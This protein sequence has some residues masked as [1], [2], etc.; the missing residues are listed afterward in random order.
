MDQEKELKALYEQYNALVNTAIANPNQ[1]NNYVD[2]IKILNQQIAGKLDELIQT[3]T[4]ITSTP[5]IDAAREELVRK[6]ARIQHDYNGLIQNTDKLE[7]L[8]RIQTFK[9]E[10]TE[11]ELKLYLF[12]FIVV[13][14]LVL[15]VML[16]KKS[17]QT[18]EMTATMPSSPAM[19]PAFT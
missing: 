11:S 18:S 10:D 4:P 14:L 8:R 6:L 9:K 1:I 19:M 7:T 12:A 15:V 17:S 13:S 16:F 5:Q 2:Q 3:S